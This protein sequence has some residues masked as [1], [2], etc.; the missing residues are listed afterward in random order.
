ML[1]TCDGLYLDLRYGGTK[2]KISQWNTDPDPER[3]T[4]ENPDPGGWSMRLSETSPSMVYATNEDLQFGLLDAVSLDKPSLGAGDVSGI[5]VCECALD[6]FRIPGSYSKVNVLLT[7]EDYRPGFFFF[8]ASLASYERYGGSISLLGFHQ[9]MDIAEDHGKHRQ[10]AH[11]QE[12]SMRHSETYPSL[13]YAT[14]ED[15]LIG[16][17]EAVSFD[18]PSLAAGDAS[19]I[20]PCECALDSLCI[21]GSYSK[22]SMSYS[23][24]K[25]TGHASYSLLLHQHAMNDMVAIHRS[26]VFIKLWTLQKTMANIDNEHISKRYLHAKYMPL[27]S[28]ANGDLL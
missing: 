2:K 12:A 4:Q 20:T 5:T 23:P 9:T 10:R 15:L 21:P 22:G 14:N 26:L 27:R 7:L 1:C 18:K 11:L 25:I 8:P 24:W 17:L 13:V 19:G 3:H 6:S 16:P 28:L